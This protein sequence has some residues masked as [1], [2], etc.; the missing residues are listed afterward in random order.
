M[1]APSEQLSVVGASA[2]SVAGRI[3]PCDWWGI[4]GSVEVSSLPSPLPLSPL[5]APPP[6]SSPRSPAHSPSHPPARPPVSTSSRSLTRLPG[7]RCALPLTR[8]PSPVQLTASTCP[9]VRTPAR[10]WAS[11]HAHPRLR[12]P[13]R[14]LGFVCAC[15]CL[16]ARA[17]ACER[18][19]LCLG[20]CMRMCEGVCV[21]AHARAGERL[22][23]CVGVLVCV[24][25]PWWYPAP[26]VCIGVYV[27]VICARVWVCLCVLA[28]PGGTSRHVCV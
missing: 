15:A 8:L 10:H 24:C 11:P 18:L 13:S 6:P 7:C 17:R 9:S 26:C 5:P 16:R 14:P 21:R 4:L 12:R 25:E 22:R 28:S 3:G 1:R 23:S 27:R 20:V 2:P 19:R